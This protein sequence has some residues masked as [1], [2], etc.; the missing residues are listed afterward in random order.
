[1]SA[2]VAASILNLEDDEERVKVIAKWIGVAVEAKTAL[3]D[4]YGFAAIVEGLCM[5]QVRHHV[6]TSSRIGIKRTGET[7][8]SWCA[9]NVLVGLTVLVYMLMS[10][11]QTGLLVHHQLP[12][13]VP[14]VQS[15]CVSWHQVR[16]QFTPLAVQFDAQLRPSL[17]ALREVSCSE[18]PNTCLPHVTPLAAL[19][20][21]PLQPAAE[22][23]EYLQLLLLQ[24]A[25]GRQMAA[26]VERYRRNARTARSARPQ[27]A[28]ETRSDLFRTE[29]HLRLLLGSR[30]AR[31]A[32]QQRRGPLLQRVQQVLQVL[33]ERRSGAA[34]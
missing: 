15:L 12:D 24:L 16:Q 33:A 4:L 29:F 14:Q 1:M 11:S 8:V 5:P 30:A 2:F 32:Q 26:D 25:A 17:R 3:G 10:A 27:D 19:L 18:A 13:F 20:E 23:P 34:T 6:V 31:A 7:Y 9:A 21:E 28:A 22:D